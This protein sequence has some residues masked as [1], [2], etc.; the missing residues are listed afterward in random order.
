MY[1]SFVKRNKWD[2][3]K[4]IWFAPIIII[5]ILGEVYS[6]DIFLYLEILGGRQKREITVITETDHSV[7]RGPFWFTRIPYMILGRE[8]FHKSVLKGKERS[9]VCRTRSINMPYKYIAKIASY[10]R[11]TIILY[12][13]STWSSFHFSMRNLHVRGL[14]DRSNISSAN[15]WIIFQLEYDVCIIYTNH[16]TSW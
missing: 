9:G 16:E 4:P 1:H 15:R 13:V 11:S 8:W 2:S 6:R 12:I 7:G 3:F 10:K 14:I 5:I